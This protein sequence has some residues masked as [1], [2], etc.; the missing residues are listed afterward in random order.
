METLGVLFT[1]CITG[2][3]ATAVFGA[4]AQFGAGRR[5][6][7]WFERMYADPVPAAPRANRAKPGVGR[8]GRRIVRR[9]SAGLAR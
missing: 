7:A 3:I 2:L 5:Q 4:S 1:W 6:R 8:A 9:R